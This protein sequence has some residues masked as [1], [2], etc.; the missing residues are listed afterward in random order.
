MFSIPTIIIEAYSIPIY[1]KDGILPYVI[2]G[3]LHGPFWK[4]PVDSV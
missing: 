2:V 4:T 1:L 3:L